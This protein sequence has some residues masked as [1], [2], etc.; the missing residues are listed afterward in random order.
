MWNPKKLWRASAISAA[1]LLGVYLAGPF[2]G[3]VAK[4]AAV[5][6]TRTTAD[7]AELERLYRELERLSGAETRYLDRID[8][9][10]EAMAEL[11]AAAGPRR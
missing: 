1:A 9:L 3:S 2:A 8:E 7:P 10:K 5:V 4:G 6:M 11:S